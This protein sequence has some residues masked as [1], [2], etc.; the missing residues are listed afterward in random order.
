VSLVVLIPAF[1]DQSEL[2]R[3]LASLAHDP[4]AFDI[5]VVDDGST[6]RLDLPGVVGTHQ[7]AMLRLDRNRGIAGALNAGVGW[8]LEQGYDLVARLDAGDLNMP[9]RCARQAAFLAHRPEVAVVGGWTRHVDEQ[10]QPLYMTCYPEGWAAIRK[11]L[12]YRT[13]FSHGAC[14]VRVSALRA[15]G[16]YREDYPFGE[17]YEL[18]W[19]LALRFPCANLTEVVVM[20]VEA[21]RSLTHANRLAMAWSRLRLQGQHFTWRRLD[22]WLGIGR[23]VALLAVPAWLRLTMK[24]MAGRVG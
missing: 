15:A 12:H 22:C 9:D 11:R 1:N 2:E 8:I 23:S 19:R 14:M 3:T 7:V 20:R 6:P 16:A 18:F 17:D 10:M 13:A 21:A 4:L 5:L 24:R